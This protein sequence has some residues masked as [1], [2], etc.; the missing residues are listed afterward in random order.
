MAVD[1]SKFDKA[2]DIEGLKHDVEDAANNGSTGN[3]KEVPH[4]T[5][6]VSV[7]KMELT[8]SKK[9]DPMV[10]IW[11]KIISG[12]YKNSLIFFNQV[13]TQ[14]FQIHI[15]NELLRSMDTDYDIEFDSYTQ[16]AQL[17]LDVHEAIDNTLEFVLIYG[18]TKKG[19]PTFQIEEVYE[20]E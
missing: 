8:E 12:E 3:Y 17:L 13:I 2:V 15:V 11:F 19:F 7:T 16:Y 6:E 9:G 10:A 5:Y 20:V 14:G 1:Y 18:E 4:G